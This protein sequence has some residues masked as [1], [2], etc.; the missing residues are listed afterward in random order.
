MDREK[1]LGA[2]RTGQLAFQSGPLIDIF[3]VEGNSSV[4]ED[5]LQASD[6]E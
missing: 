3:V 2:A 4:T 1:L 6:E 5:D